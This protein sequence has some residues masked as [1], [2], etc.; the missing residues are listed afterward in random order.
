[1]KEYGGAWP[2]TFALVLAW[3]LVAR[4]RLVLR[5]C[6]L[7]NLGGRGFRFGLFLRFILG[8]LWR[9]G[10]RFFGTKE[11]ASA[12]LHCFQD[13]G[14]IFERLPDSTTMAV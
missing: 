7:V 4:L 12:E 5:R 9:L 8:L 2:Q 1:M 14:R 13:V 6:A 11:A 10:L 3:R